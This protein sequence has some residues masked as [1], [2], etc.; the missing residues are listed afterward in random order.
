MAEGDF[1]LF[2]CGDC[3]ELFVDAVEICPACLSDQVAP[4]PASGLAT[5]ESVTHVRIP[6]PQFAA[7]APVFVGIVRLEASHQLA[8]GRIVA[9]GQL[10]RIGGRFRLTRDDRGSILIHPLDEA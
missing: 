9:D 7:A 5:L 1:H 2:A 4:C 3:G 6:A 8:S 10:P